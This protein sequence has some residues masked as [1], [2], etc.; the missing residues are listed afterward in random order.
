MRFL[1][2]VCTGLALTLA[3]AM[4]LASQATAQPERRVLVRA[5]RLID[6]ATDGAKTDQGILITGDR[7]TRVG[8]YAEVSAAAGNAER[9]DLS[10]FTVLPGFIDAHTHV[11]LDGGEYATQLLKQ[12][13]PFRTI[14]AVT[15]ARA[16]LDYGFTTIRDLETEGAMY[17]DVDV[18]TA[19]DRGIIPGP[20]ML[21]AT[22]ALAPTGMY[23]LSGYSWELEVPAGAQLVDGADNLRRAVREQ[24]KFGADWI[25][26][27]ADRD[28]YVGDD[29][30]LHSW[31]NWTDEEFKAI[32][33]EARRLGRSV[34]AHATG[35]EGIDAALRAGVQSIEH[36]DGL[37][38]ELIDRMMRQ[39][40]Y[41]CPTIYVGARPLTGRPPLRATMAE[42]KRKAF[43]EAVRRGMGDLIAFGTD[44]GG[45]AWTEN[46]AQE[47]AYY[48]RYGMTPAQAIRTGTTNA[49]RLLGR[50]KD[51]G[52]V[53]AGKLA[54]LVA[55][56][57]DPLTDPSTLTRARW[58]MKGG[59]TITAGK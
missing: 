30:R 53:V 3:A 47:F 48:V 11:F 1:E 32:V 49:A 18:K 29:G 58:V 35:V 41:W 52:T 13:I 36:G 34:A 50:D 2:Q 8:P 27:Y 44:A 38:P 16:A 39:R 17:A 56:E 24:V 59:I 55:V 19:I 15:A 7:I 45:F 5:G 46:P 22:R 9:V 6:V 4:P 42:F 40:V 57:G 14:E 54:D 25:K 10:R 12:S 51:V 23:P 37:T 33:D 31:S 43:G 28:S 21:V 20:R 26:V